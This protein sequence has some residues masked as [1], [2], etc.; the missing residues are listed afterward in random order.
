MANVLS[1][2]PASE[3]REYATKGLAS[4]RCGKDTAKIT[5]IGKDKQGN[6]LLWDNGE[7]SKKFHREDL[8]DTF[9][10]EPNTESE[11]YVCTS[12]D[13]SEVFA[14][15]P[16][17]GTFDMQVK[18]FSRP[19]KDADPAP[20]QVDGIDK[21]TKR[22]YSGQWW[23]V[24]WVITEECEFQDC[25]VIQ[26]HVYQSDTAGFEESE[27]DPGFAGWRGQTTSEK[28]V[29]QPRLEKFL[30]KHDAV[31]K[32]IVW[33]E[34]DGNILPEIYKRVMNAPVKIHRMKV[35]KGEVV[36]FADTQGRRR[37]VEVE[38]EPAPSKN[39]KK[40]V[41]EVDEEFPPVKKS[42][43]PKKQVKQSHPDDEDL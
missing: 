1:R 16:W 17:E 31:S 40:P 13:K 20:Y 3:T 34:E 18:D 26:R 39:G 12:F 15:G 27:T 29:W 23:K 11:Y 5:F 2:K 32:P 43:L 33:P 21:K 35:E 37:V 28:A 38:E 41:D 24:Q 6:D 42:K 19:E 25:I 7:A 8:P 14:I 36:A 4:I 30:E 9:Q 22:P 10:F